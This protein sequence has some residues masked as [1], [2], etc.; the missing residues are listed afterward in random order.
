MNSGTIRKAIFH[1]MIV[2]MVMSVIV[3]ALSIFALSKADVYFTDTF[4]DLRMY[5]EAEN[6]LSG[7][8]IDCNGVVLA[9]TIMVSSTDANGKVVKSFRRS[10]NEKY[11]E[12]VASLVGYKTRKYGGDGIEKMYSYWMNPVGDNF[13]RSVQL[14]IDADFQLYVH[15]LLKENYDKASAVVM[16]IKSGELLAMTDVPTYNQND[17]F[18]ESFSWDNYEDGT[19][20]RLAQ[21]NSAPGS[22]WKLATAVIFAHA[23]YAEEVYNDTGVNTILGITVGNY[24][25]Q[26]FGKITMAE[27]IRDSSN[28]YFAE[29]SKRY[30]A[31]RIEEQYSQLWMLDTR[32]RT[33]FG[34][35]GPAGYDL[36]SEDGLLRSNY[37]EGT[38][39]VSNIRVA[40]IT[41]AIASENGDYCTPYLIKNLL[42]EN[43]KSAREGSKEVLIENAVSAEAREVIM[44]G[45]KMAAKKYSIRAKVSVAAKTGTAST[46]N[47]N[48]NI[49]MVAV[50]PAEDP[51]Y[52]VSLM[53]YNVPS[54]LKGINLRPIMEDIIDKVA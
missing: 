9:E 28:L 27:A 40:M 25:E 15:N 47:G 16:N 39:E 41:A 17:L 11:T 42:K 44:K 53:A 20:N 4:V 5:P 19:C 23:G 10:Y 48:N 3:T 52:L 36:R 1:L 37:G 49:S 43:Q 33:D 8:I 14:T 18:S 22:V 6:R 29:M 30:G 2:I 35:I 21:T 38:L 7:N 32:I 31:G 46:G 45:M 54:S 26:A 13:G 51:E 50:F 12:A 34:N 24:G